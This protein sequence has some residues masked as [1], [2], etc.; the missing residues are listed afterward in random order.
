MDFYDAEAVDFDTDEG[1]T[2][3]DVSTHL[4]FIFDIV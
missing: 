2:Q 4:P 1:G 3:D